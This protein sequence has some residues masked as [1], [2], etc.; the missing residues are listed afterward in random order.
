MLALVRCMGPPC[1]QCVYS[2]VG[3]QA[4]LDMHAKK[5][6]HM[7]VKIQNVLVG[8]GDIYKVPTALLE[9]MGHAGCVQYTRRTEL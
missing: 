6:V 7:D 1:P 8:D 2:H 5:M 3:S 4:L 9:R